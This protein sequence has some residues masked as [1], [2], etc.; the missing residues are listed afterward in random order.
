MK[1]SQVSLEV[2]LGSFFDIHLSRL[3]CLCGFVLSLIQL[4]TVNLSELSL[5][6]NASV[7]NSSNYKRLLR[8]LWHLYEKNEVP[9]L[10]IDRSNWKFGRKNIIS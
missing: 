1:D 8:F 2:Q 4:R 3:K 6:L 5:C 9:V 10:S 7:Y